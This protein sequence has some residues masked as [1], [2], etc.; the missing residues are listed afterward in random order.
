M[1][2]KIAIIGAGPAGYTVAQELVKSEHEYQIDIFDKEAEIGGAIY[3][4]IP[5][6]RMPKAFLQKAY[7]GLTQAGVHFYFNT[8][9]DKSKF[10]EL[11]KQYDDVVVAIGAQIENTFGFETGHGVVAGLTLLYDLN[12]EQKQDQYKSYKKAI[13]WGGGNVAMDCARSLVRIIDDVTI[14]Y[15]R[16]LQEM[17]ASPA[18]IKACEKEGVKIA[19]LNNIKDILKDEQGNVCG[20]KVAKMELGEP[21]ESGRASC[22]EVKDSTFTMNC[23]LVA[24]AIGQKIDFSVLDENLKPTDTHAS[25][26]DHVYIIGDAFT[27]PKTIGSA[28]VEGRKLAKEIEATY[29]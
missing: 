21:D 2:R 26:L 5:N 3:T 8:F 13:V 4:G 12:I 20:V 6:Y 22:H 19:F 1:T 7:D 14:V 15:R 23:D 10:K 29:E 11:Q 27:G 16:S 9:I 18:E 25:T 17:P 24:M 28:V